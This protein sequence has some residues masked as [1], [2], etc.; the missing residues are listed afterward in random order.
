MDKGGTPS[1]MNND[2]PLFTCQKRLAAIWYT[3]V[4][5]LFILMF[6]LTKVFPVFD[7]DV[8]R[9]WGWFFPAILPMVSLIT[10]TFFAQSV[11]ASS[12]HRIGRV[13]Y[14]LAFWIS[15][16][17]LIAVGLSLVFSYEPDVKRVDSLSE[18]NLWL[19]PL[20]GIVGLALGAFFSSRRSRGSE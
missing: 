4:A 15:C 13:Y 16:F 19:G 10:G 5:L 8:K 1:A 18:S 17:Y 6:V 3:G 20:Q 2:M 11:R 14:Q 7:G 9:A 12:A